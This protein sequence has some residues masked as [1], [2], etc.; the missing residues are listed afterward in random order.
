[1]A[2]PVLFFEVTGSDGA[3]L[4]SFFGDLFGW[5]I[6][7]DNPMGYG[8]VEAGEGGMPGGIG[9]SAPGAPGGA[10][11]Y[12]GTDDIDA[13]L[14]RVESLGGRTLMPRTR[15]DENVVIGILADPE[16]HPV[17]LIERA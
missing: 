10:T 12:V 5:R 11:F 1:M 2:N 17:G 4:Q 7:T 3:K 15:V 8:Y 16:G 9:G 14:A 6:D 13:T